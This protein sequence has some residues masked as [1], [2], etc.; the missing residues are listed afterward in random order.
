[1]TT[2][3]ENTKT[4]D[5]FTLLTDPSANDLLIIVKNRAGANMETRSISLSTLFTN[6]SSNVTISNSAILSTNTFILRNRQTPANST[7]TITQ[8]TILFDSDYIYVA[9][10]NNTLKRVSL[11]S[12]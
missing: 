5:E 9:T 10:A 4:I 3:T 2:P 12:F 11:S 8:G 7:I 6:N 1:M